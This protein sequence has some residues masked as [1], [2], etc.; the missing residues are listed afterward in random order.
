MIRISVYSR[1][2]YPFKHYF[3]CRLG[4]RCK[5]TIL[6]LN[7]GGT[8]GHYRW[9]FYNKQYVLYSPERGH[10]WSYMSNFI[11]LKNFVIAK[12]DIFI[13]F[14]T[15]DILSIV[16]YYIFRLKR[17]KV[18]CLLDENKVGPR[19][20][21]PILYL[22]AIMKRTT[23]YRAIR[24]ADMTI[25]GSEASLKLA[26][27]IGCR[28]DRIM[29]QPHGVELDLFSKNRTVG[30]RSPLNVLY[31]GGF[32]EHKGYRILIQALRTG[33]LNRMNFTVICFGNS[34]AREEMQVFPN[35]RLL[36]VQ[37]Y[38]RM[39]ELYYEHDIVIMP[40]VETPYD[41]ERS[42]NVLLEAMAAGCA[43]IASNIG[44]I[45]TYLGDAGILISPNI[46]ELVNSLLF[47]DENRVILKK[48][49]VLARQRA[50]SKFSMKQY[51]NI[52]YTQVQKILDGK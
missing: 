46:E 6:S 50:Q 8:F 44:G 35:V 51:A 17:D 37:P 30:D 47:L 48:L 42:P 4:Q 10:K 28:S 25:V 23:L 41:A 33:Q 38:D 45:P 21:N 40:S 3:Y 29:L 2:H 39:L 13:C 7:M 9:A 19:F 22:L 32:F 24:A 52:I 36:P 27:K 49:S 18:M 5:L 43:V 16:L 31:A 20:S 14:D 1:Y 12:S 11:A 15:T 26:L 34:E